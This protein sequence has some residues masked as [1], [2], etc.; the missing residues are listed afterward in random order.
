MISCLFQWIAV[1]WR[2]KKKEKT[3][4]TG[5]RTKLIFFYGRE[6]TLF[7]ILMKT[8]CLSSHTEVAFHAIVYHK[9]FYW[10][11]CKPCPAFPNFFFCRLKLHIFLKHLFYY[12]CMKRSVHDNVV[13]TWLKLY[14]YFDRKPVYSVTLCQKGI[15]TSQL[16][17]YYAQMYIDYDLIH[18]YQDQF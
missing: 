5:Q 1:H 11:F 13:L 8:A 16:E 4:H 15:E 9:Q 12:F 17:F 10:G 3:L 14:D 7:L 2:I 6:A 18:I